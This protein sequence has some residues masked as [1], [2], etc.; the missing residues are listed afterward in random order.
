MLAQRADLAQQ[1]LSELSQLSTYRPQTVSGGRGSLTRRTPSAVPAAPE[2]T[3]RPNGQRPERDA[4]QV[5]SLLSSFQ[6]GTS[7]GRMT[8]DGTQTADTGSSGA[9]AEE[10]PSGPEGEQLAPVP[11]DSDLTQRS[12]SW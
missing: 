2:I 8:A 1:A 5:R 6:S 4:N 9:G 7:R 12:T 11:T 10:G 3:T